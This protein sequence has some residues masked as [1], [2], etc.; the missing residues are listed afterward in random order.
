MKTI[1]RSILFIAALYLFNQCDRDDPDLNIN[2]PDNNFLN[3]LIDLGVDTDGD[4]KISNSEAEVITYLDVTNKNISELSGIENFINLDTLI[5]IGNQLKKLDVSKNT[6]LIS[7]ICSENH[8][9]LLNIS[10]NTSLK[11]LW[12]R[13]NLLLNIDV[14]NNPIL[15]EMYCHDNQLKNLD[16]SRNNALEIL[17]CDKNLLT[18]LNVSNNPH[19]K[20]LWCRYNTIN[21]LDVSNNPDLVI[22]NCQ[23]TNLEYLDI[24]KNISLHYVYINQITT[25]QK[26]CV[27]EM[28]FPPAGV[29]ID[30][31]N[32]PNLYFTT[33][34]N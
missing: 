20:Q 11:E 26:V 25:L 23:N 16:I 1:F 7:L 3:A 34:C 10:N 33:D 17:V 14:S 32:S 6:S 28:P 13:E 5:C 12:C 22:L 21:D 29:Y 24:S 18:E 15:Q 9:S 30:T 4:R 31:T 2:I 19:L 8:I 27:W